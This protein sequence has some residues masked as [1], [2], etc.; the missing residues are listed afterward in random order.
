MRVALIGGT[1]FVGGYLVDA[2]L[3]GGHE[4]SVLVRP[5]SERKLVQERRCRV[6]AGDLQTDAAIAGT[7]AES[8]A[9][10]YNVGI[11]RAF[12]RRGIT[13]E[14]LQFDGVQ[15]TIRHAQAAGIRRLLLMSA[16][17]VKAPGTP[18][19]ETKYRAEQVAHASGLE[20]TVFRPSVIF[21]NPRGTME[22]ASQ[23]YRDMV[24]PPMPA[25]VLHPRWRPGDG[26]VRM[27]PVHA[28][29]V[30]AAFVAA[31]G[32]PDTIG[33]TYE[34]GGPESLSWADILG[35]VAA[36]AGR[37]KW[38]VPVPI[39]LMKIAAGLLD[40]WPLFP[41]TRDQLIMLAEGNTADSSELAA[42][43][44]RSPQPF[45]VENLAYLAETES[46]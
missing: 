36:A 37:R 18:Y 6:V 28:E 11:L 19:Q 42:L 31:L 7:L 44:G 40:R 5:G 12:P 10:I 35:R 4:P 21:G 41:V 30:A 8:Q 3:A 17:G 15:R 25:A 26:Q 34:L 9:V 33:R 24:R 13:F 23:L 2:L 14:S 27:S 29:D 16:N 22:F 20:V 43:I 39:P 45:S 46:R 1:G 38:Q 32:N